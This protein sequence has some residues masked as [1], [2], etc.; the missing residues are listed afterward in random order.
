MAPADLK[1]AFDHPCQKELNAIMASCYGSSTLKRPANGPGALLGLGALASPRREPAAF[2]EEPLLEGCSFNAV[3]I[4]P[5]TPACVHACC[6]HHTQKDPLCLLGPCI[7]CDLT[8]THNMC[9][10]RFHATSTVSCGVFAGTAAVRIMSDT[11]HQK[12]VPSQE[13]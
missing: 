8:D 13:K 4:F 10:K 7:P 3:C 9:T 5:S 11:I 1:S 6:I 2:G 12:P